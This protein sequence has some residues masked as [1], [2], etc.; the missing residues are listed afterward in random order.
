[1][2][3][4][5]TITIFG[6]AVVLAL[7]S[8]TPALAGEGHGGG[9]GGDPVRL[10]MKLIKE[11]INTELRSDVLSY[12]KNLQLDTITSPTAQKALE[13]MLEKDVL[14]DIRTSSYVMQTSCKAIGGEEAGGAYPN[15]LGGEICL[16]AK[17]LAEIGSSKAEIVGLAIHEHAH[18]FGYNDRDYAIYKA[19]YKTVKLENPAWGEADAGTPAPTPTPAPS[20]RPPV[21]TERQINLDKWNGIWGVELQNFDRYCGMRVHANWSNDTV[22]A[23]STPNRLHPS[24]DECVGTYPNRAL[25]CDSNF[26]SCEASDL[27]QSGYPRRCEIHMESDTSVKQ[28][29]TINGETT[30]SIYF[31]RRM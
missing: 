30:S 9:N 16:S 26:R 22:V 23:V 6:T 7:S 28:T 3:S 21:Q 24:L 1:M 13:R 29:C 14:S 12:M 18:H 11:Y 8:V 31:W 10:R 27:T 2:K 4:N 17:R 25:Y 19:V 20:P 15:D 5:H